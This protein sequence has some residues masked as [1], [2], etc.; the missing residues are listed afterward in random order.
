M[1][2]LVAGFFDMLHSGHILF[3]QE[4]SKL[5]D[6]YVS[7]GNDENM[8]LQKGKE[9]ICDQE[10]RLMMIKSLRCIKGAFINEH[11]GN[12]DFSSAIE[13]I[14]PEIFCINDDGDTGL[15]RNVCESN[16]IEYKILIHRGKNPRSS[17]YFRRVLE[18]V[19]T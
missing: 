15:K 5:G 9:P 16:N 2:V 19:A 7:I 6:L 10:E 13:K 3:L 14:K 17:S 1:K 8:K 18:N 4:A 12:L 11:M